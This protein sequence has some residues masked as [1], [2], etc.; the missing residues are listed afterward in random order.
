MLNAESA[1]C[2]ITN[3][4]PTTYYLKVSLSRKLFLAWPGREK[5]PDFSPPVDS[6][7]WKKGREDLP[8]PL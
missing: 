4:L 7:F 8:P 6:N 2:N 5:S 1:I 3:C